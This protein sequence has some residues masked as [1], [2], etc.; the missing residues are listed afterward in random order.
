MPMGPKNILLIAFL[1]IHIQAGASEMVGAIS[2]AL[3]GTGRAA[4]ESN[5]SLYLNPAA[6]ALMDRFYAG[7][8]WQS[9]FIERDISRTSYGVTF[10]DGQSD[11]IFPGS[12]GFRRNTYNQGESQ[13]KENE[14]K[15]GL[16]HRLTDRLSLGT[17][18]THLRAMD[19]GG[20]RIRQHNMDLG[21]LMGLMPNWGMSLTWENLFATDDSIPLPLRR[22]SYVALG[23]QYLYQ[24]FFVLRYEALLPIYIDETQYISHRAGLGIKMVGDFNLNMGFSVDDSRQQNW[25]TAGLSWKGPRLRLAYSFQKE[26]RSG[27]GERHL[28]DLWFDI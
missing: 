22:N 27:L 14:F 25:A 4:V 13:F 21:L 26:E 7:T 17:G 20:E 3:G 10:S 19:P 2:G 16:S 23:T 15:L 5:E 1:L 11:L 18:F 8:L 24:A 12:L 6:I 28:V 9:G